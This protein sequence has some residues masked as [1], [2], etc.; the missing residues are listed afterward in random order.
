M[1][2]PRRPAKK[3]TTLLKDKTYLAF[4]AIVVEAS[5]SNTTHHKYLAEAQKIASK[6][7]ED[8]LFDILVILSKKHI[9]LGDDMPQVICFMEFIALFLNNIEKEHQTMFHTTFGKEAEMH[10]LMK[11]MLR[12]LMEISCA[13]C[14]DTRKLSLQFIN[15]ILNN[16]GDRSIDDDMF[17]DLTKCVLERAQDVKNKIRAEAIHTGKRLQNPHNQDDLICKTY[18]YHL[19]SDPSVVVR[20]AVLE[21][22]GY[23]QFTREAIISR[24][25]DV[26]EGVRL[27]AFER[28]LQMPLRS[29]KL[30]QR[31]KLLFIGFQD[32]SDK[33]KNFIEKTLLPSWLNQSDKSV[34][35]LIDTIRH[36][37]TDKKKEENDT[38]IENV[39]NVLFKLL[40]LQELYNDLNLDDEKRIS[41]LEKL[42]PQRLI[43]WRSFVQYL[44]SNGSEIG[45]DVDLILPTLTDLV[46]L[47]CSYDE[48]WEPTMAAQNPTNEQKLDQL[49][50]NVGKLEF[51]RMIELHDCLGDEVGRHKLNNYLLHNALH[52]KNMIEAHYNI[53][54]KILHK[55]CLS[56]MGWHT[57]LLNVINDI[58]EVPVTSEVP[59]KQQAPS[60]EKSH[61]IDV[62]K[63]NLKIEIIELET[64]REEALNEKNYTKAKEC[65]DK[66]AV[67]RKQLDELHAGT[68]IMA[69][70]ED[71][72]V[73]E[74]ERITT[75]NPEDLTKILM[76]LYSMLSL[77]DYKPTPEM[78]ILFQDVVQPN[79]S[80][81]DSEVEYWAMCCAGAYC[82][83]DLNLA[84]TCFPIFFT[85]MF[86]DAPM[87]PTH[88]MSSYTDA[89]S[90][91][92]A[93]TVNE[94]H[95]IPDVALKIVFDMILAHSVESFEVQDN[96]EDS[97]QGTNLSSR[98]G[99]RLFL[100]DLEEQEGEAEGSIVDK[101]CSQ[102]GA[103]LNATPGISVSAAFIDIIMKL[104]QECEVHSTRLI[105]VQGLIKLF[106]NNKITS[107]KIVAHLLLMYHHPEMDLYENN[108]IR[109]HIVLLFSAMGYGDAG[110]PDALINALM[111]AVMIWYEAPSSSPLKH[112]ECFN[113]LKL[114]IALTH[115]NR[116]DNE[117]IH[118]QLALI[119]CDGL[120]R[121]RK[122]EELEL[123]LS[124]ALSLCDINAEG[125]LKLDLTP[126]ISELLAT[127]SNKVASKYLRQALA[128]IEMGM[129]QVDQTQE[130]RKSACAS[131][132][133]N[134][135]ENISNDNES[136]E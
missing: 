85:K 50:Y 134:D 74:P 98:R 47:I 18:K 56:F 114:V 38:V 92:T 82:I 5:K 103:N 131:P 97:S 6:T 23:S 26:D 96:N 29:I 31:H 94:P 30:A 135:K 41:P 102:P 100:M 83:H 57:E 35:Y 99:R 46:D 107:D 132:L 126:C 3:Q 88:Q 1:K 43:Y 9:A 37:T 136:Q 75:D 106:L 21:N 40:P 67:V 62:K 22:I 52:A 122:N 27:L 123:D 2:R 70:L 95:S 55:T 64:C 112:I 33:I 59:A 115:S 25:M 36:D 120:K 15:I 45:A 116:D 118:N 60:V 53:I 10:G 133:S 110:G 129:V 130:S 69:P 24:I 7:A 32:G 76:I 48:Y 86:A 90:A 93:V 17:D 77:G 16:M 61:E 73:D 84:R 66:L 34:V 28:I 79:L 81:N 44:I 39:L 80:S 78:N 65:D 63:A 72:H 105:V 101:T 42:S 20:K 12:F 4:G 14:S 127:I 8:R 121:I 19:K 11:N 51:L 128:N 117:C 113:M 124:K 13:E 91:A 125:Q 111:P 89:I 104:L 119:L 87:I 58:Y 109:Q 49:D 108:D 68:I 54:I 71:C